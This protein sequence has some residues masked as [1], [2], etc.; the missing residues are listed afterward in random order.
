MV[1]KKLASHRPKNVSPRK[2]PYRAPILTWHGSLLSLTTVKGGNRND[3]GGKPM[4][5]TAG[6]NA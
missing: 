6:M 3:G 1:R 5:R 2:K 4:T